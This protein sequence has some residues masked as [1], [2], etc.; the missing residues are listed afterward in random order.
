MALMIYGTTLAVGLSAWGVA[1][2]ASDARGRP[3]LVVGGAVFPMRRLRGA[4]NWSLLYIPMLLC[5]SVIITPGSAWFYV[6]PT[7]IV[8]VIFGGIV[9]TFIDN[10][11]D[12]GGQ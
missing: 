12:R 1:Y 4:L 11:T 5:W 10:E 9:A 6:L 3:I 8:G 2:K 7:V